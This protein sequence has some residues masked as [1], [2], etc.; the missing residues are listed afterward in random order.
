LATANEVKRNCGMV[1]D[2]CEESGNR[3][4]EPMNKNR[5]RGGADQDKQ[6]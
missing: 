3:N 5:E 4:R 6:A 1:T 2:L